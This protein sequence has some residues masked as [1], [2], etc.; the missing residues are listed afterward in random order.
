VDAAG[1]LMNVHMADSIA[2]FSNIEELYRTV[3]PP[4]RDGG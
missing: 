1:Y 4:P 2:F 3:E